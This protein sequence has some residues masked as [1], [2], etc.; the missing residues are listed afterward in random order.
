M[1]HEKHVVVVC[2]VNKVP[3]EAIAAKYTE[4]QREKIEVFDLVSRY[5]MEGSMERAQ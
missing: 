3:Q 2:G 5:G 1:A 4:A